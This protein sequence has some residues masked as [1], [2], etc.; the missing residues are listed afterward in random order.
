MLALEG[1]AEVDLEGVN[2]PRRGWF[3][4]SFG[5]ALLPYYELHLDRTAPSGGF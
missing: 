1:I 2:S 5:G 4:L 3:K